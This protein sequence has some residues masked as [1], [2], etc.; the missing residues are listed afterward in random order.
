PSQFMGGEQHLVATA[1]AFSNAPAI[2]LADEPTGNLDSKNGAHFFELLVKLNREHD[3]TLLLVTHDHAL[4]NQ[5]DRVISLSDG[6]IV[7]D[8]ETERQRDRETERQ[9]EGETE[10]R[11][12]AADSSLRPSVPPSL[13]L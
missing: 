4:A 6:R 11:G 10:R 3:T 2:L 1:R 8:G 13:L 9:R 5:A 12:D 7:E